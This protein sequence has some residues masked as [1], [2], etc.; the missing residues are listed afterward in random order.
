MA[1]VGIG[2]RL[3]TKGVDAWLAEKVLWL[4]LELVVSF[5]THLLRTCL[6]LLQRGLLLLQDQVGLF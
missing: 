3:D 4:W 5:W 2:D 6:V 1:G